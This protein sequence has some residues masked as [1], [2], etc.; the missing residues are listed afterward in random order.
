MTGVVDQQALIKDQQVDGKHDPNG[1]EKPIQLKSEQ[2]KRICGDRQA[3]DWLADDVRSLFVHDRG[4]D[5]FAFYTKVVE[6]MENAGFVVRANQNRWIW[7]ESG[8]PR[9]LLDWSRN[10]AER[11]RNSTEIQQAG[12]REAKTAGVS[13]ATGTCEL[14]A[15]RN[16]PDQNGSVEV[17]VVRMNEIGETD[18]PIQW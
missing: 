10:L 4:S 13:I 15:P 3:R 5:T 11:G 12:G 1:K 18:D 16:D 7:A 14:R 2:E 17:N 8:D 6:E 9:K